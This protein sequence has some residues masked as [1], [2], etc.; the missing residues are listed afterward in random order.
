MDERVLKILGYDKIKQMLA[1]CTVSERGAAAAQALMPA[2]R[3]GEAEILMAQTR[4]AESISISNA[5]HPIMGFED[6]SGELTRLKAGAGL[7][8]A[9]L[10]RVCRLLKAARRA[11]LGIRKDE[12]GRLKLLPALAENLFYDIP[13]IERIDAAILSEEEVADNASPALGEIRR[14]QRSEN[15][16]VREKLNSIIR[17]KEHAAHLQEAIITMR[18]GRYVVPVK[19]EYRGSLPGLIHGQSASGATLFIEPMSIVEA[20]NRLRMLEEE[21]KQEIERI[22]LELSSLAGVFTQQ[23]QTDLDILTDLDLVF[24][25]AALAIRM[26]AMPIVFNLD[27]TIDIRAGRHPLIDEGEVIP[28]S[29]AVSHEHRTLIITGPNTG[30]KTVTLKM[31]GLFSAMAQSGLFLP[32]QEGSSLPLF[33]KIFADIGDEQSI[34]QSLSTFSS[35]MRNIIYILRKA[36]EHCLVLIDELGAGTDPE[37]GTALALAILEELNGRGC[38]LLA[39]THYSEIKAYAMKAEGFQN[40]SMEFDAQ[41]LK[42]TYRLIMG[43]AGSS[44]AFLISKRLGLRAPIIEK[45]KGF[46]REERLEFDSLLLQAERTRKQAERELERARQMQE[47]A[48]EVDSR[49]KQME[50]ELA[51]K[52]KSAI[53]RAQKDALEIVKKAQ[54]ETEALISEAKKLSRQ[55]ESQATRTTQRVRRELSAKKE[56]LKKSIEPGQRP[57][58]PANPAQLSVGDSVHIYSLGVD[59][60]VSSLP[61]AKGMVGVQAGIMNMS[62][63]SSDLELRAAPSKKKAMRTSRVSLAHKSVP[64]SL[65]LHGY[66]VEEAILEVDQYL[67][68]A[69]LAGLT[70]ISII[71][72]KGTGALRSGIQSFLRRHPHVAAFRLG[73]FGEGEDGVTIVTLK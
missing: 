5:A 24:A 33:E 36:G 26:R 41:S 68:D 18:N 48:K 43:V 11:Q 70:E 56:V 46:M 30:G 52:R 66:T 13:L 14:R 21:E 50:K 12:Q 53:Q 23:M 19:Q 25:K 28:V 73:K 67:D 72:G 15:A 58:R 7:S 40:A 71:H 31:V 38:K 61:D 55:S 3:R 42:P 59:A 34:E 17:S 49:A 4:E 37:E 10:L 9:E 27:D 65:N 2:T 54:E 64:L 29:I 69:F 62:V 1:G 51:D 16:F 32:A 60:T 20:N 6:I 39:T 22:L 47:H 35:H 44:N 8:C 57:A 63:H 45:A